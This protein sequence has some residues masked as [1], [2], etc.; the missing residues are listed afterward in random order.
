MSDDDARSTLHPAMR[1]ARYGKHDDGDRF[2]AF[3][4]SLMIDARQHRLTPSLTRMRRTIEG[5]YAGRDVKAG[6]LRRPGRPPRE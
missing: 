6:P 1:P 2:L 3:W 4:L 5:F